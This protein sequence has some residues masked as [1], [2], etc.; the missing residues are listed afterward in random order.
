MWGSAP[1]GGKAAAGAWGGAGREGGSELARELTVAACA[2]VW[3]GARRACF[4]K[5]KRLREPP[6]LTVEPGD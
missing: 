1:R 6:V 4:G 5:S 2:R 3:D